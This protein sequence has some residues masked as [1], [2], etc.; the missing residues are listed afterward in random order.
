MISRIARYS[1][2]NQ[3]ILCHD[4][5]YPQQLYPHCPLQGKGQC[6]YIVPALPRLLL[7]GAVWVPLM[8]V[9]CFDLPDWIAHC[10][11][12]NELALVIYLLQYT[13]HGHLGL[14]HIYLEG[15]SDNSSGSVILT[16]SFLSYNLIF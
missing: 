9:I 10:R 14:D 3:N 12:A 15:H 16:L 13:Y 8:G 11:A 4:G 7:S 6:R 5:V 1:P 2:V